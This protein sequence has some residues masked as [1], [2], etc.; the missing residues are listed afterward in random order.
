MGVHRY[1]ATSIMQNMRE[2]VHAR[3]R[4]CVCVRVYVIPYAA[5][6]RNVPEYRFTMSKRMQQ[7]FFFTIITTFSHSRFNY[8]LV[9]HYVLHDEAPMTHGRNARNA[10]E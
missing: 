2:C 9:R 4:V 1:V 5:Y 3:A 7:F 8:F 6:Y 10:F